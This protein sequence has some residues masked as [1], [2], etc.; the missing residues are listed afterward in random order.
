MTERKKTKKYVS[1]TGDYLAVDIQAGAYR[2]I[3]YI[4]EDNEYGD[5]VRKFNEDEPE[6]KSSRD[7]WDVWQ[8]NRHAT[9]LADGDDMHGLYFDSEARAHKALR[10]VNEA[11]L[12]GEAPWP[13]WA[14]KA[15]EAG[16]TMPE[17][18]KP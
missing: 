1:D 13:L 16:W 4:K 12:S 10:A 14:V 9:P 5:T 8:A 2:L 15:K 17:G 11:L 18:W 3:W 7:A 6:P